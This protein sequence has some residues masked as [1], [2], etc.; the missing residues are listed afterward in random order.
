MRR[1]A[2]RG[3]DNAVCAATH[4]I[5][6]LVFFVRWTL[7]PTFAGHTS[8]P[9]LPG[10]APASSGTTIEG[11]WSRRGLSRFSPA[12]SGDASR[13]RHG[14][15][16]H[17]RPLP[18]G[19]LAGRSRDAYGRFCSRFGYRGAGCLF[20]S[21]GSRRNSRS[22][23]PPGSTGLGRGRQLNRDAI[24]DRTKVEHAAFSD[25]RSLLRLDIAG[26]CRRDAAIHNDA[27]GHNA[28]YR[29]PITMSANRGR[30]SM[31]SACRK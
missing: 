7:T 6:Q 29:G 16:R 17:P 26:K 31:T 25:D 8:G 10:D 4:G 11:E 15:S 19:P 24:P 14:L 5:S 23:G 22:A 12:A 30:G 28:I 9:S 27:G 18:V 1:A 21:G 13:H 3:G 20:G 2:H